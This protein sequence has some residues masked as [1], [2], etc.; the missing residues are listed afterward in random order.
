MGVTRL[1]RDAR[2]RAERGRGAQ[3]VPWTGA[4]VIVP[5]SPSC[6]QLD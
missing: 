5:N 3:F 1:Q 6:R 4:A 2:L